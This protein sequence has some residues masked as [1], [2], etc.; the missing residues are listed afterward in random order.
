VNWKYRR[1]A[2]WWYYP[3]NPRK[4][5]ETANK[6]KHIPWTSADIQTGY[7]L[8]EIIRAVVTL[9]EFFLCHNRVSCLAAARKCF[10]RGNLAVGTLWKHVYRLFLFRFLVFQTSRIS[11]GPYITARKFQ[12]MKFG[13]RI[14]RML[15][16]FIGN[17]GVIWLSI[18]VQL[19]SQHRGT[20]KSRI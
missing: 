9:L 10:S 5:G 19:H 17:R 12:S 14:G 7:L 6:L 15:S 20:L 16:I 4:D 3:G 18:P 1:G 2:I 11:H 8:K 13:N